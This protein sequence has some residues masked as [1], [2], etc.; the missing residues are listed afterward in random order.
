MTLSLL[1]VVVWFLAAGG[2]RVAE[3]QAGLGSW[4]G[5]SSPTH[6]LE[7]VQMISDKT[8][9]ICTQGRIVQCL[10]SR[11][12]R[13]SI[14]KL[15][16]ILVRLKGA[17]YPNRCVPQLQLMA[18]PHATGVLSGD[19]AAQFHVDLA[20]TPV[21]LHITKVG[22]ELGLAANEVVLRQRIASLHSPASPPNSLL[23]P[24][25]SLPLH[26]PD[27]PAEWGQQ[28]RAMCWHGKRLG[29]LV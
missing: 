5:V 20:T 3:R 4:P 19:V 16:Q 13:N 10:P 7:K 8:A 25:P 27:G 2:P 14:L 28:E 11:I 12:V 26:F 1:V 15:R 24:I 22:K 9:V 17:H 21:H 18:T 23:R 6:G 29:G